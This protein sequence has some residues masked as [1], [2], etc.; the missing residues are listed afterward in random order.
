MADALPFGALRTWE[1]AVGLALLVAGIG[2]AL[3]API[4]FE[5]DPLD[6]KG[7]PL[8]PPFVDPGLPLGTD[9]LGR[10]ILACLVH[11]A[12]A[13]LAT[14]AGVAL[15]ALLVGST[16][17]AVAG[18]LG[19][20]ADEV[21]MRIADATQTV[22]PFV[23]ALALVSVAGPTQP[24]I[25][26]A[27]A[28]GAWTGPARVVRAQVLSLR[29]RPFVEASRLLGRSPLAVAVEVVLPNAL[30]PIIALASVTVAGA[31]L[32]EAALSF[33]GLGDPNRASWGALIAEGRS[34]LRT[35]P[36]VIF[37][38]GLAVTATVLAVSLAGEGLAKALTRPGQE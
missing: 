30:G 31:I 7:R 35:A 28:A 37:A 29:E 27:L 1:G 34:V 9:R 10:D 19:G 20:F 38:P 25:V 11:G 15:I 5:G 26:A 21:L 33:L 17:G 3:L 8:T 13:T 32:A 12:R 14:S 23:L 6:L 2:L 24:V 16:V 22:P 18:Y 36:H 4:L